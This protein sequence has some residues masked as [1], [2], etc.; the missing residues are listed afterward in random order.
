MSNGMIR[1]ANRNRVE[2]LAL[3]FLLLCAAV[4]LAACGENMRADSRVKVYEPSAFYPNAQSAR[5]VISG[6]VAL[7]QLESDELLYTGKAGGQDSAEF[8][9]PVT[10]AV[11]ERGQQRF[12]IYCAPCHGL[13]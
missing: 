1:Q 11:I 3:G 9:F 4:L 12:E 10:R 5:A 7:G 2:L 13:V 8:P 6:T